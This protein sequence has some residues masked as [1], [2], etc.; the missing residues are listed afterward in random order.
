MERLPV[1]DEAGKVRGHSHTV[2][3]VTITES[4][5]PAVVEPS[6]KMSDGAIVPGLQLLGFDLPREQVNPG[7]TL[8]VALYWKALRDVADDYVVV[9]ELSDAQGRVWAREESRPAYGD[10]P[11]TKWDEGEVIRDWHEPVV[12]AVPPMENQLGWLLGDSVRLLGYDLVRSVEPGEPLRLTLYWQCVAEMNTSYT[13]FT[14]LLDVDN[15]VRGQVDQQPLAG[16]APTTSW[17]EGEVIA[18][19]YEI[20]VGLDAPAGEYVV[21]IGMYEAS[22]MDRLPAYDA[23]GTLQGDVIL[24]DSVLVQR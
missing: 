13:V 6:H 19:V 12:D 2:G 5:V 21:E 14:H 11:T 24:L 23:Q 7:E 1:L 9:V 16:E 17:V 18:D 4:P 10:Y 3:H 8:E 22:T 20:P 15:V